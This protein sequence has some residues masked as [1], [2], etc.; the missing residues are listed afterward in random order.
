ME[1]RPYLLP[2]TRLDAYSI[3]RVVGAGGFGVTY[4][5]TDLNLGTTVAIK[6]YFPD[7]F[8]TRTHDF[9]VRPSSDRH[10]QTFEWG[11]NSFLEEARTLARFRHPSIVQIFRIFEA[12]S[13]AY[14]V[15]AFENGSS[16]EAWL[17]GLG[18]PPLQTELD[19]LLHPL[20]DALEQ[21]HANNFL[22]RDIAPDNIII[23]S[24]M[25]PVLLDFGA[26]RK[27]VAAKTHMLTGIFKQGYSPQEQYSTDGKF[28][29]P[30]SDFYAL[31]AILYRAV[32]GV[33]PDEA[34][35]RGVHDTLAPAAQAAKGTY[36]A[37]FLAGID[38][39]LR[40]KPADRPQTAQQ[41]REIFFGARKT[42]SQPS[43]AKVSEKTASRPQLDQTASPVRRSISRNARVGA[44]VLVL[45]AAAT[46]IGYQYPFPQHSRPEKQAKPVPVIASP[47]TV[48]AVT[49]PF[50]GR[51]MGHASWVQAAAFSPDGRRIASGSLDKTLR[52]WDAFTGQAVGA[53][54]TGHTD[55]VTSVAFSPDNRRIVSASHDKTL[56][57]WDASSGQPIGQPLVGHT[58]LVYS[59][60]FSPDGRRV[61]SASA[62]KTIRLWD[63][64]TGQAI[65]R[66]LTGHEHWVWSV[67]FSPDGRR[68]ASAGSFDYTL[69]LW[70]ASTGRPIG[71]PLRGHTDQASSVAFSPDGRR[72][73]S[74]G[75]DMTVRLWDAMTGQPIGQP[76]TGHTNGVYVA[77]SPDGRRIASTSF[78]K[79]IRFWD[80]VAGQPLEPVLL[81]YAEAALFVAFSPDGRRIASSGCEERK[82]DYSCPRPYVMIQLVPELRP[83]EAD[84]VALLPRGPIDLSEE[85]DLLFPR[86]LINP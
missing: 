44:L 85:T 84:P 64:V 37:D 77:F 25:T 46:V 57:L 62:D 24:D 63:A 58:D 35:S 61:A 17:R 65:G 33:P 21:M 43:I 74:G 82:A 68:I 31:G 19:L 48:P 6:E 20:L 71:Q 40:M 16:L 52:Q 56:R 70:D 73:V 86:R 27:T 29:G 36:R 18:R 14:M 7:D 79:T 53:P 4:E 54:L 11:R 47:A 1:R 8:A 9:Q 49:S 34:P 55:A 50:T 72:I 78:D 67:A 45:S 22:H 41:V 51:L 12:N 28:Q 60:A 38:A 69:R 10:S 3:V 32:T 13:T 76:L 26:A 66:P 80:A 81:G 42:A 15:M 23:R 5:A 39:C 30:W 2:D 83:R 59:V 75:A